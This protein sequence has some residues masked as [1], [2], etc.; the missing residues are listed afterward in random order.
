[1]LFS[2]VISLGGIGI[3]IP[4][5]LIIN[6]NSECPRMNFRKSMIHL[7][8][9]ESNDPDNA[10]HSDTGSFLKL[11]RQ[12]PD[13][14]YF[15]NDHLLMNKSLDRSDRFREPGSTPGETIKSAGS[16]SARPGEIGRHALNKV[17]N[18]P[19]R[20]Q[21]QRPRKNSALFF[22]IISNPGKAADCETAEFP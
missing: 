1:M 6:D 20:V 7:S 21:I 5:N 18:I 11:F 22:M 16:K 15:Y 13:Y 10:P 12:E 2:I 14:N 9:S 8:R 19:V 17:G 3:N 4:V